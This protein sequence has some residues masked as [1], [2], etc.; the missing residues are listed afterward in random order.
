MEFKYTVCF[1][2]HDNNILMLNRDKAPMMGIWNGLGGKIEQGETEDEAAV[3]EVLEATNIMVDSFCSKVTITWE[4]SNGEVDGLHVFLYEL[5]G[6]LTYD[7]PKKMREGIL[8]W[9]S[10]DWILDP[11]NLGIPEKLRLYLPFLLKQQGT[12]LLEYKNGQMVQKKT[13]VE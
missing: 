8:D 4:T 7:T 6:E 9:K 5:A 11:N 1:L 10:I 12:Y 3:C 13:G 2:K